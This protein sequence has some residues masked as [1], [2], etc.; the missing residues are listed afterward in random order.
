MLIF[1]PVLLPIAE[2]LGIDPIHFGVKHCD[3]SSHMA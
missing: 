1:F 2:E 3:G